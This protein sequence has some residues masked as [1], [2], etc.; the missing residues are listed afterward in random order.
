MSN[1]M[2]RGAWSRGGAKRGSG[3][4]GEVNAALGCTWGIFASR[5]GGRLPSEEAAQLFA[6]VPFA[7]SLFAHA[8]KPRRAGGDLFSAS[9]MPILLYVAGSAVFPSIILSRLMPVQ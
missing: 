3:S 4:S 2:L 7:S 6:V 9:L 5:Y 1:A 8:A